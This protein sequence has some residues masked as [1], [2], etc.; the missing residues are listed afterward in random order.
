MG[1]FS[2]V[3]QESGS[4]AGHQLCSEPTLS[5]LHTPTDQSSPQ[6]LG[7]PLNQAHSTYRWRNWGTERWG[8]QSW[9]EAQSGLNPQPVWL[10][11]Q[12]Y[13]P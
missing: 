12:N 3:R 1:G 2:L 8:C 11:A 4:P 7:L 13:V 6:V 5:F 9:D 10:R